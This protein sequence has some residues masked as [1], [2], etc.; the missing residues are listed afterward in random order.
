MRPR[1]LTL[2]AAREVRA[3]LRGR[4][5]LVGAIAFAL[6]AVA[7]AR[8]GMAGAEQWGVAA[9]DRTAAALLNLVLL[10]VPLLTLPLG[11]ASFAGEQEDGTLGYLLAQ[12]VRRSEVFAGK[13]LGLLLATTL[14][15]L[16]GFGAAGAWIGGRG[17]VTTTSFLALAGG[18]WL[19]GMVTTALGVMLS[20]W[21]RSRVRSLAAAVA[22]WLLLVFLCDFGVLA[23]AAAQTLGPTTL[24]WTA[25]VN[26]LQAAKT[27][28]ALAISERL[29]I[30]GPAGVHAVR[31]L[32]RP[33][34]AVLLGGT[35]LLW[36]AAAGG[37]AF[38]RFRKE[39]LT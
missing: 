5:F 27:L 12:P 28:S 18:A 13:L 29:E 1:I 26:P 10:F 20:V 33:A 34:L 37:I 31:A 16:I 25:I 7:V 36:L 2:L 4:W 38:A 21:S 8:L 35:L 32:G 22:A 3:S 15:V 23:L 6:L 14:S 30:L 11:A 39:N 17:G 19:L 9:L 24:F